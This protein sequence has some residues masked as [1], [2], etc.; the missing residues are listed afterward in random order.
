MQDW[1][2]YDPIKHPKTRAHYHSKIINVGNRLTERKVGKIQSDA[3]GDVRA[4]MS[5][6]LHST[7]KIIQI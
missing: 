3:E 4:G 5:V 6:L 2:P 7:R 1:S